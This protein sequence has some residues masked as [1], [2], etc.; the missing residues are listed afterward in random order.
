MSL[1]QAFINKL[2]VTQSVSFPAGPQGSLGINTWT[3]TADQSQCAFCNQ[4]YM[5]YYYGGATSRGDRNNIWA[6]TVQTAPNSD[7]THT[8]T[9]TAVGLGGFS[10]TNSGDG[11]TGLT[12]GT[13]SGTYFGGNLVAASNGQNVYEL[14]GVEVDVWVNSAATQRYLFAVSAA[15]FAA[16]QGS[17]LDAAYEVHSGGQ[18]CASLCLGGGPYGPGVGFHTGL[19][20][21]EIGNGAVPLDSG[22]TVIK[23]Y[24]ETLANIPVAYGFDGRAFAFSQA[25]LTCCGGAFKVDGAGHATAAAYT[26][27]ATAGV[28]CGPAAPTSAFH[29]IGGIVVAC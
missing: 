8:Q 24:V 13:A 14:S 3:V 21:A 18:L 16:S 6:A 11:G 17:A 15:N 19:V 20:F 22:A 2:D 28:T 25:F 1:N 12:L 9:T 7:A 27:G 26:V 29:V 23:G 5:I 10:F 4:L